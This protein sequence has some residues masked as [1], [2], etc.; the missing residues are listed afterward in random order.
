VPALGRAMTR[1]MQ[2]PASER[3][4]M[5]ERARQSTVERYSLTT[6]L[7]K[8]EQMYLELMRRNDQPTRRRK[9]HK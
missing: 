5:G 9:P 8:W 6:V 4:A 1:M 3:L 7:D 2:I